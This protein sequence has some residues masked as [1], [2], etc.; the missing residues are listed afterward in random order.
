MMSFWR[1]RVSDEAD[2]VTSNPK[3][4][5]QRKVANSIQVKAETGDRRRQTGD[6]KALEHR[7]LN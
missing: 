2:D 1:A 4:G 5:E 3:V 7:M 6:H